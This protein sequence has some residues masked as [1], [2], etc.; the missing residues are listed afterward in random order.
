MDSKSDNPLFQREINGTSPFERVWGFFDNYQMIKPP[1]C[2]KGQVIELLL[3]N[4]SK[5]DLYLVISVLQYHGKFS[6]SLECF[7]EYPQT[8]RF[9]D[10]LSIPLSKRAVL[11]DFGGATRLKKP[12]QL[13]FFKN[14]TTHP[15]FTPVK[16]GTSSQP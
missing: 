13:Q 10:I 16:W 2:D 15:F 5:G 8:R 14:I 1:Y 11:S 9:F 7:D 3:G 6:L 12:Y 4:Y